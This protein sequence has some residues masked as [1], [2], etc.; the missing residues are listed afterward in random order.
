[1][2]TLAIE[3]LAKRTMHNL[4]VAVELMKAA[5]AVRQ[6][7]VETRHE[8]TV[9]CRF[10]ALERR[11]REVLASRAQKLAFMNSIGP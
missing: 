6:A 1:M 8:A 7:A 5:Q 4:R 3:Q 10:S 11:R 2:A 9:L